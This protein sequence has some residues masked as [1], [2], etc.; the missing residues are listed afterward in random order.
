MKKYLAILLAV[1]MLLSMTACGEADY[2]EEEEQE[3]TTEAT[4]AD[5][6]DEPTEAPPEEIDLPASPEEALLFC[7]D[8]FCNGQKAK[9]AGSMPQEAWDTWEDLVTQDLTEDE[10]SKIRE[11]M[12]H[13]YAVLLR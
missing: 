9:F 10:I 8:A 4:E 5:F 1:A 7:I 11:Y 3:E 2:V 13:H 12:E 6:A